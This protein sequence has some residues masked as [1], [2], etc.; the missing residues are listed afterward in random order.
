M[1]KVEIALSEAREGA[2]KLCDA[3]EALIRA[4]LARRKSPPRNMAEVARL[5]GCTSQAAGRVIK[6]QARS[7]QLQKRIAG[8]VRIPYYKL[9]E[10]TSE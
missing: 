3:R 1:D 8:W 2:R 4:R 7:K 9:W 6:G 5:Y 10:D